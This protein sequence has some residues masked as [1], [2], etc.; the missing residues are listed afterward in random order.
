[1]LLLFVSFGTAKST[2]GVV[3][4]LMC[5]PSSFSVIDSSFVTSGVASLE[6]QHA[7]PSLNCIPALPQV[8]FSNLFAWQ[9]LY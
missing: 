5:S 2:L 3:L 6:I 8:L 9:P 4:D 1:M 7:S